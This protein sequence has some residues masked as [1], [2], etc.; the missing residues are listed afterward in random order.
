MQHVVHP[1]IA[2][3]DTVCAIVAAAT[4]ALTHT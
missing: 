4:A 2:R 3:G 1:V